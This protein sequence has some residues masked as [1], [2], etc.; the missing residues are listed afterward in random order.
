MNIV[1]ILWNTELFVHFLVFF[2]FKYI[3]LIFLTIFKSVLFCIFSH[4]L[5][6]QSKNSI[7][8]F[9]IS[10]YRTTLH[11]VFV[12]HQIRKIH[13]NVYQQSKFRYTYHLLFQN[14]FNFSSHCEQVSTRIEACSE[15]NLLLCYFR[16]KRNKI[17]H[18]ITLQQYI[19]YLGV[20]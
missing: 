8:F 1:I 13:V 15:S 6:R 7:T 11:L 4:I 12:G 16:V 14:S 3:L 5:L 18:P 20:D 10:I 2:R 17:A 9:Y 19:L